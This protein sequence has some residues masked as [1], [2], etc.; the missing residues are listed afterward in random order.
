MYYSAIGLLAVLILLIESHEILLHPKDAFERPAWK[1]YRQFLF[2]VLGYYVTDILWGVLESRKLAVLL[3][4]DTTVYFIA[5]AAGVLFWAQFIVTYLEEKSGFGRFLINAGRVIAGLIALLSVVNIFTPV[6]FTV[7]SASVYAALP[8]RY[9]LLLSQILL[10]L[11]ISLYAISSILRHPEEKNLKY[12]T[13]ACFGLIMAGF[14]VFQLLFPYDPLYTAAYMLGT[15]MIHTF[16]VIEEKEEFRRGLAEAA[17]I[18]EL[19]NTVTALLDNL[20]GMTFT[21]D[22]ETGVYLACNQAFA[23]YARKETPD[24][25]IGYVDAELFD[26]GTAAHFAEDDR[27]ALSMDEPYIFFEDVPNDEGNPRQFQTTKLKYTDAAGRLC[28]LGIVQDVTD[29]TRIQRESATTVEAYEKARG[30]GIMYSH[31]AQTMARGFTV[32]FYVNLDSEEFIEYRP[33]PDGSLAEQRRGWHFFEECETIAEEHIISEDRAAVLEALDRKLLEAALDRN[34]TVVHTFRQ[35][36][37]SGPV[38]VSMQISRMEDD[39]RYIIIGIT[40]IDEHM[41]QRRATQKLREEQLAYSRLSALAG[42]FLSIYVVDPETERY[43]EIR[44]DAGFEDLVHTREGENFFTDGRDA[45][46]PIIHPEDRA[47]C[48]SLWTR[49]N[50]MAE[51]ARRG[52]FTLSFRIV[53][54]SEARYVQLKAVMVEE[55]GRA[56]LIVGINDI[57]AQVRQEEAYVQS[58][59]QAQIEAHVD[60]LTGVKNRHAYLEAEERLNIQIAEGRVKDFAIVLL[61]V[62]DLKQ[63]NDAQGHQAGDQFLMDACKIIC[64]TFKHSPVYRVGGDEFTVVAQ[65][66]DYA[67]IDELIERMN[68]QNRKALRSGGIVIACGMAKREGENSV[69]PVFVRADQ[70][71]YVN[72][73]ELKARRE[74]QQ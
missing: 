67:R 52:S 19:K 48:L 10:F 31:I 12:R 15:S 5:M 50:V 43:R 2:A 4:A 61:D 21:K 45:S 27:M 39:E 14:L 71:M 64:E 70:L 3:F 59:A 54:E 26:A 35:L 51:I 69:A 42:N 41:K 17:R 30:A 25:V 63:V 44:S 33:E 7:D 58:L 74:R 16:V 57:D 62:N 22:A 32:L 23:A 1:V 60:P 56:Q 18:A 36:T 6:L 38:Y 49:D 37:N 55:D 53:A 34:R 9:A 11:L 47:R 28:L 66:S 40:D 73:S 8:A 46:L 20:P 29:M 65:G 13:L 24:G 72:K 68:E